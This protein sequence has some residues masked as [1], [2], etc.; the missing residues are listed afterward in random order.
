MIP[1]SGSYCVMKATT[2]KGTSCPCQGPGTVEGPKMEKHVPVLK[3]PPVGYRVVQMGT[4]GCTIQ[5]SLR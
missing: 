4:G 3:E 2:G 1:F 5:A